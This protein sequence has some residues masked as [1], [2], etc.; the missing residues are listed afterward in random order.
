M[1]RRPPRSTLFPY[2]TLFRSVVPLGV[3]LKSSI[4]RPSSLPLVSLSC[5]RIQ[6]VAAGGPER[7][8]QVRRGN[9]RNPHTPKFTNPAP[10]SKK[11]KRHGDLSAQPLEDRSRRR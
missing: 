6:K 3:R 9:R 4:A 2:T 8:L 7:V 5:Q 11:K 1:I 10:C